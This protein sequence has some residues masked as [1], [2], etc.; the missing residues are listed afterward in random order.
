MVA[1]N[2]DLKQVYEQ[3][4]TASRALEDEAA[5]NVV[6][7]QSQLK[8]ITTQYNDLVEEYNSLQTKYDAKCVELVD[9]EKK[10]SHLPS[11]IG[12]T[13]VDDLNSSIVSLNEVN[14]KLK[15]ELEK[16]TIE[17][18]R[19][20]SDLK[21]NQLGRENLQFQLNEAREQLKIVMHASQSDGTKLRSV[22]SPPETESIL[23]LS[24]YSSKEGISRV[25]LNEAYFTSIVNN[26]SAPKNSTARALQ[27][28]N[29]TEI[30]S[31]MITLLRRQEML[32]TKNIKLM[33]KVHALSCPI[34][35]CAR[36]RLPISKE[37]GTNTVVLDNPF[38]ESTV[39]FFAI[40]SFEWIPYEFDHHWSY[41]STQADVFQDI[42]PLIASV[43]PSIHNLVDYATTPSVV[44]HSSIFVYGGKE[45][46]KSFTMHGFGSH[47]GISYRSLHK[48][49]ELLDFQKNSLLIKKSTPRRHGAA[50][51]Y[52]DLDF[53]YTVTMSIMEVFDDKVYD[54][55]GENSKRNL[56]GQIKF[57]DNYVVV[58]G[59]QYREV[60]D[61]HDAL[62]I[63]ASTMQSAMKRPDFPAR[64]ATTSIIVEIGLSVKFLAQEPPIQCRLWLAELP[65][66]DEPIR[67]RKDN[68]VVAFEK[69]LEA[70]ESKKE[71]IPFTSSPLTSLFQ[72]ALGHDA[73]A[74]IIFT[75]APTSLSA[76]VT[77]AALELSCKVRRIRRGDSVKLEK[78]LLEMKRADL[79]LRAVTNELKATKLRNNDIEGCLNHTRVVAEELIRHFNGRND[80]VLNYYSYEKELN[81]QLQFDLDMTNKNLKRAIT[82][83]NDQR[84]VNERLVDMVKSLE[85]EKQAL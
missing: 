41:D 74:L 15:K 8:E 21:D 39:A 2:D 14:T 9:M 60:K 29:M 55:L 33:N 5:E 61:V 27:S 50:D 52:Q 54:L 59:L 20:K 23:Q 4:V 71:T 56:A 62:Q 49:F 75:L 46:G 77:R 22:T 65:S 12:S 69:V 85:K 73:R 44:Q 45:S 66:S 64:Q 53:D 31:E 1:K 10:S 28:N 13:T 70:M 16:M 11:R 37:A 58:S 3:L 36:T 19:L 47:L 6:K 84:Y 18:L 57:K 7:A 82:E 17:S 78:D 43:V 67:G 63:L 40:K 34:Q 32:R 35:V 81:K 30:R 48:I 51:A 25:I 80:A 72:G 79:K 24:P 38:N 76:D 83:L 68:N 26:L 42:E